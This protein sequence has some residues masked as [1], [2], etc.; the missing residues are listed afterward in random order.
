MKLLTKEILQTLPKMYTTASIPLDEKI[1]VCK[2]FTPWSDWQW[3]VLEGEV[4]KSE[5]KI[6]DFEF[7]GLVSG[8]ENEFGYFKLSELQSL[9]GPGGLRIERDQSVFKVALK[10][11]LASDGVEIPWLVD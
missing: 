4:V 6:V 8:Q 3:Y 1:V 5:G 2:F 7:F 11:M 9:Y 10:E